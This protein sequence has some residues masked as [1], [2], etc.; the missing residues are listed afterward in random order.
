MSVTFCRLCFIVL[1]LSSYR[2]L[3][4]KVI[5]LA[6]SEK[7]HTCLSFHSGTVYWLASIWWWETTSC[8]GI[9]GICDA[10]IMFGLHVARWTSGENSVDCALGL[11]QW[12]SSRE[13]Q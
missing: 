13:D 7:R 1:I 10:D 2:E 9:V 11:R 6:Q 3:H 4:S 12:R 8:N 5:G